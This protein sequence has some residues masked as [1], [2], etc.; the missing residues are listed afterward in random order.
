MQRALQRDFFNDGFGLFI[1]N[2][3][4]YNSHYQ[5]SLAYIKHILDY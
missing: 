2:F 3:R 5:E 1:I 4:M